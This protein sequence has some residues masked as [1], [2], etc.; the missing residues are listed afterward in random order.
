MRSEDTNSHGSRFDRAVAVFKNHGGI[1]RTAQALRLGIH[2]G[3]AL[4]HAG[5]RCAGGGESRRISPCRQLT[6]G[7]F[8]LEST[9]PYNG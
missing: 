6:A 8:L 7:Q 3:R 9:M 5:L 1:L 2:P 4:R